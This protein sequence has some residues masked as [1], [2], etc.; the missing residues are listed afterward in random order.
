MLDWY[1]N[2]WLKFEDITIKD[3]FQYYKSAWLRPHID[4]NI[5]KRNEA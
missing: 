4:F 1:L 3:E 2:R 5:Q